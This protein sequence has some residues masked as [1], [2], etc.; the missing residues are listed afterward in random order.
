MQLDKHKQ[1]SWSWKVL[2][3]H[4][5]Q[6]WTGAA[7]KNILFFLARDSSFSIVYGSPETVESKKERK[8]ATQTNIHTCELINSVLYFIKWTSW[9]WNGVHVAPLFDWLCYF[10]FN[11]AGLGSVWVG[12][13]H[14][15]AGVLFL[16]LWQDGVWWFVCVCLCFFFLGGGVSVCVCVCSSSLPNQLKPQTAQLERCPNPSACKLKT[17]Q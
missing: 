5:P 6:C 16:W 14:R 8:K 4:C 1:S 3:V 13:L 15:W 7:F 2:T 10:G 11:P 12:L 17:Q 9:H